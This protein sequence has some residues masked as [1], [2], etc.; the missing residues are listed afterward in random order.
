MK[1]TSCLRHGFTLIEMSISVAL[2][3]IIVTVAIA[4]FKVTSQSVTLA[5]RMSL[6]NAILRASVVAANQ[7]M[8]FWDTMDSR[9]DT[10][11]QPLRGATYPFAPMSFTDP[12]NELRF[13]QHDSRLWWNGPLWTSND[14]RFGNYSLFGRQGLTH[15]DVPTER[16]WRHWILPTM[17]D[18]MG[19]YAA[20]DYLPANFVYGFY[21]PTGVIPNEFGVPGVGP[22]RFR[23]NWHGR[24]T[25]LSKLEFGHDN[26]CILTN[27]TG[28]PGYPHTHPISHRSSYNDSNTAGFTDTLYPDRWNA[29]PAMEFADAM[30]SNWP[31]V[32]MQVKVTYQ[33][34]DF[35]HQVRIEQNDP[36]T[37][38][39][40]A[41]V[42]HGLTTTLRG[43]RRQR[44]LDTMSVDPDYP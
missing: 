17:S 18:G 12:T 31:H 25:P 1:S 7:E 16:A 43:A 2:G 14:K 27:T 37:G 36:I 23:S 22:G 40:T 21:N 4:G 30:P 32:T 24:N 28:V 5:N 13:D 41:M 34:M 10:A 29:F 42:L 38:Q 44:G 20:L 8:D 19:Y 35:R 9:T 39:Q 11:K 3:I 33:W 6:Q 15:V 26:G